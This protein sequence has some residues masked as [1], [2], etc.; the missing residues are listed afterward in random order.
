MYPNPLEVPLGTKGSDPSSLT[1]LIYILHGIRDCIPLSLGHKLFLLPCSPPDKCNIHPLST[2][3]SRLIDVVI[4][5]SAFERLLR[6]RDR[7]YD[8]D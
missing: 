3:F 1:T 2:V 5:E 8:P 7:H 4:T 6:M